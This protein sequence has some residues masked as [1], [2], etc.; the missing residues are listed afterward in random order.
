MPFDKVNNQVDFPAQE[1]AVLEFWE[2]SKAF[3]RLRQKNR[4][5]PKWSFLDGPITANL[6]PNLLLG[7]WG[8]RDF[9]GFLGPL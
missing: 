1:R 8:K 9:L 6:T 4:G 5:K 2:R 3:E 7:N